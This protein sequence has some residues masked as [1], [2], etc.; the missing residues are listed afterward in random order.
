MKQNPALP[1]RRDALRFLGWFAA[2][3][4]VY[5]GLTVIPWVD[6]YLIYSVLE[7]TAAGSSKLLN[8]LGCPTTFKGVVIQGSDFA[9]A[10]QRGCDPLEPIMLFCAAIVAFPSAWQLKLGGMAAGGGFLF[11][12]NLVRIVSLYLLGRCRSPWY[13][14]LHQEWWPA[15]FI[16]IAM[17]LWLLWLRWQA[18]NQCPR[19]SRT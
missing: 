7:I 8:L 16:V 2:I 14:S 1:A 9:V 5:Y 15:L 12:L 10:V 6:R 3:V 18:G 13:Y 11:I 4:A 19:A 17:L